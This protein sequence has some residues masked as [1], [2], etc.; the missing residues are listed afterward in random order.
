MHVNRHIARNLVTE[1][2]GIESQQQEEEDDCVV[3][4]SFT[5]KF[6]ITSS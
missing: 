4:P 2:R 3:T 6:A 5:H 1:Q